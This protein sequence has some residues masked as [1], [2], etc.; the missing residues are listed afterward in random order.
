[1]WKVHF[2]WKGVERTKQFDF[3]WRAQKFMDAMA[4][5]GVSCKVKQGG[6]K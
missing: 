5:E 2:R 4:R 6:V 3:W 1:M